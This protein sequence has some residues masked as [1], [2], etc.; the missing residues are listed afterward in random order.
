MLFHSLYYK[1]FWIH[2]NVCFIHH[3]QKDFC[4]ITLYPIRHGWWHHL[5]ILCFETLL[6][7]DEYKIIVP[8]CVMYAH[9]LKFLDD[10]K[11]ELLIN[12][13]NIIWPL[14]LSP[15]INALFRTVL[16]GGSNTVIPLRYFT[17]TFQCQQ[18]FSYAFA[19]IIQYALNKR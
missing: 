5:W 12:M 16:I 4:A 19:H 17:R 11:Q 10:L 9:S 2:V 15:N 13:L 1:R 8:I 14:A 18:I 6:F 7:W 3:I